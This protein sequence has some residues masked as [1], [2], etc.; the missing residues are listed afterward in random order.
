M[1]NMVQKTFAVYNEM[2]QIPQENP[3]HN[4]KRRNRK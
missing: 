1:E 3:M 4:K 2:L